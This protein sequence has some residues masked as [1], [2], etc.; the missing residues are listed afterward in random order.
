MILL[1]EYFD[2]KLKFVEEIFFAISAFSGEFYS[3]IEPREIRISLF[4]LLSTKLEIPFEFELLP[5][6][7][8]FR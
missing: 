3:L 4:F 8:G 1:F 6:V 5:K 2:L 7:L